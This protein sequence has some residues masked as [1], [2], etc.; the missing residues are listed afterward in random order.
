M[1]RP[2]TYDAAGNGF[3][4]LSIYIKNTG[5][6]PLRIRG[7]A[8]PGWTVSDSRDVLYSWNIVCQLISPKGKA[9]LPVVFPVCAELTSGQSILAWF[10]APLGKKH[11]KQ[12][13]FR[14]T[15][16]S[17]TPI[18]G[19]ADFAFLAKVGGDT[20]HTEKVMRLIGKQIEKSIILLD[21]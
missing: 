6:T 12:I 17:G 15:P 8:Y 1:A 21:K 3:A 18:G 10:E 13:R 14:M 7:W 16:P 9:D 2:V 20:N 4:H 11:V 5:E 19:A